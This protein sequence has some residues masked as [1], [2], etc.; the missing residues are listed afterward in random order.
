MISLF[1]FI[2]ILLGL[3]YNSPLVISGASK[4]LM[5]WYTNVLPILLPFMLVSN[6]IVKKVNSISVPHSTKS[7]YALIST[8]L[9]GLLCGYPLGAKTTSDYVKTGIFSKTTGNIIL[10][11]C[12]NCSPMFISGYVIHI[13]LKDSLPFYKTILLIYTPYIFFLTILITLRYI[14]TKTSNISSKKCTDYTEHVSKKQSTSTHKKEDTDLIMTGITQITYVGVYIMICSILIEFINSLSFIPTYIVPLIAGITEITRG[15]SQ[16]SG[17]IIFES[18]I[19]KAL[20]LAIT[21]FGG[22]SAILQTNKV[23]KK[24][25]LSLIYYTVFKIICSVTTFY[26]TILFV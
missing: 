23:I 20:I 11:I 5:L 13:I 15:L 1:A 21:S 16:I 25:G 22:I 26:L 9:L 8:F 6:I 7:L 12:N 17:S 10:P 19:K 24:S 3:V 14:I 2:I 4:G 18:E